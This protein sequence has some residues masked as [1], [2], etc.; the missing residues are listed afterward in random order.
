[1]KLK[2]LRIKE[3]LFYFTPAKY[4]QKLRSEL[5]Y[6][7][8]DDKVIDRFIGFTFFFSVLLGFVIAFDLYMIGWGLMGIGLGLGAGAMTIMIIQVLIILIADSRAAEVEKVLPDALQLMSANIRAGMTVD[9]AIWLAARP[10]FGIF[11]EE[12]R[13]VGAKTV[14]GKSIKTALLEIRERIKSDILDK[15]VRLLIEGIESG[16]ELANLLQETSNNI[17]VMQSVKKEI[18]ASVTAYS[19]FIVFAAVLAAPMLYALSMFFVD[20]MTQ[21]WSPDVLGSISSS[22]GAGMSSGLLANAG[23][24]QI[25]VDQIFWFAIVSISSTTF[26]GALITGLIQTGNEKNGIKFIPLFVLGALAVFIISGF[27]IDYMFG[28]FFQI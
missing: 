6:A 28:S 14:G 25:S 12:I 9:R 2:N 10:E 26:F 23:A 22:S 4:K 16:G 21:L 20:V 1:M 19:I 5:R 7:G 3:K 17:R 15:T 27:M 11:E 24:P 13:R 18:K 8:V